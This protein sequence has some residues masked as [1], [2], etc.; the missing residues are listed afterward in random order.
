MEVVFPPRKEPPKHPV[1]TALVWVFVGAALAAG[2]VLV[3]KAWPRPPARRQLE[4]LQHRTKL[5]E[6]DRQ[7]MNYSDAMYLAEELGDRKAYLEN[8]R[9]GAQ[10]LIEA[11]AEWNRLQELNADQKGMM[12]GLRHGV[13]EEPIHKFSEKEKFGMI[14]TAHGLPEDTVRALKA[15]IEMIF[16]D[17]F[18]QKFATDPKATQSEEPETSK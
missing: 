7:M 12:M 10:K 1:L 17:E 3:W 18:S 8:A 6:L 2:G 15:E 4:E 13:T 16:A 9:Q 5:E 11:D 14:A